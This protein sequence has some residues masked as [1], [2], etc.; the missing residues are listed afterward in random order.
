VVYSVDTVKLNKWEKK[1]LGELGT[2]FCG[3]SASVNDVNTSGIGTVYVTGPEQWDGSKIHISKWT[4]KPKRVVPDGCIF[5]TVKGAG[6]GKTFPGIPCAIG[7]DVYAFKPN[8][9]VSQKFIYWAI[10]FS[11]QDV[12]RHAVGDIPGISKSHISDHEIFVPPFDEQELVV[13]EIE[14]QFSR[15]DEAVASLKRIQVNLKRYKAAVLKAAVEGKLTEQWRKDHPNVEPA[16]QLLKRILAERRAK[17]EESVGA[18]QGTSASPG[19]GFVCNNAGDCNKGEAGESF[20]SPLPQMKTKG[21]KPKDDSWKKKYKE[22]AGP[23]TANLPE[24]PEGWV[25]ATLPQLGELNR[26]KSKHRPR[27]APH[28]NGGPYPFVQ[29]GDIRAANGLLRKYT[30]TYSEA[31]LEQSRLWPAGT[32]CITIAANIADTAILGLKACFPDSIVGFITDQNHCEIRF[33]EFFIRTAKENIERYAPA[34]AQKNINLEILSEVAAP[35][36][37]LREQKVILEEI[38]RR[39]SVTEELE[40]TIETNFKRAGRLRQTILY[41]AFSGGLV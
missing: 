10:I 6:V 38:D 33:M 2:L 25:W 16:D 13:A 23:D 26:G 37:P 32:L 7:R 14:K 18:K 17:W 28:L 24:M 35:L 3:Q 29:T 12:I 30:Q 19:F 34:T 21:I 11:V 15:L 39:L 5:I 31:G 36:P 8:S 22:P 27:N 20:A 4:T 9:D 1:N 41:R 40:A